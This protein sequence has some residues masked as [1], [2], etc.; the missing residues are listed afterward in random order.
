MKPPQGGVSD[1]N[2]GNSVEE[3]GVR[4]GV[5][6]CTQVED[7]DSESA[8]IRRSLAI[9]MGAVSVQEGFQTAKV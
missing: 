8:A 2:R 4:N 9:F 3:D 6:D 1:A 5:K 7:E